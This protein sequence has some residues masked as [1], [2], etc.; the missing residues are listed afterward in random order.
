MLTARRHNLLPRP[1]FFQPP[2]HCVSAFTSLL[3]YNHI[4][5]QWCV[6]L[7]GLAALVLWC[8]SAVAA[9]HTAPVRGDAVACVPSLCQLKSSLVSAWYV[10][11][12][13]LAWWWPCI[14][15]VCWRRPLTPRMVWLPRC[16][17]V[18]F[19]GSVAQRPGQA[20]AGGGAGAGSGGADEAKRAYVGV[21][22]AHPLGTRRRAY[23]LHALPP[24]VPT[25]QWQS[26]GRAS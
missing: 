24:S 19:D 8:A 12:V 5:E 15:C 26:S 6:A 2:V 11:G 17:L 25:A 22:C 3:G 14:G 18:S 23:S 13:W 4:E 10:V 16:V 21:V 9:C 1:Q 7:V 20:G